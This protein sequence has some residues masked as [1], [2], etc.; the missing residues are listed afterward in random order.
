MYKTTA[1]HKRGH[2]SDF[3]IYGDLAKIKDAIADATLGM[4]GRAGEALANSL[5]D[6]RERSALFQGN[7]ETLVTDKP[8]KSVGIALL[9]GV[10]LGYFLHK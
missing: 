7:V 5:N 6:V 3:D 10:C 8:F 1:K 4:K 9:A 2:H